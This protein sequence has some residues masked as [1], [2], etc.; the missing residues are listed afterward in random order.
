MAKA[1]VYIG[2]MEGR[3]K[4]GWLSGGTPMIAEGTF[5]NGFESSGLVGMLM[6]QGFT[7]FDLLN[8]HEFANPKSVQV[9]REKMGSRVPEIYIEQAKIFQFGGKPLSKDE[10]EIVSEK[11]KKAWES[12]EAS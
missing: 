2:K 8:R 12:A 9:A 4:V 3:Y 5:D 6:N 7:E 1:R 11:L 10:Y